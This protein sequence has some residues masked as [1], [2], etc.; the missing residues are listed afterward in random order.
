MHNRYIPAFVDWND[1]RY[2]LAISRSRTLLGAA[3]ALGTAHTTV[4]RRLKALEERLGV[5]LFDRTPDGLLPTAAGD[6]LAAVAE[7]VEREVLS[8]EG[9]VLGRDAQLRGS[10]R[11]STVDVV[12]CR[13]EDAFASFIDRYPNI[14]LSITA[15]R[16]LVSLTRREADVALRLSNDPPETLV[17]RKVGRVQFGVY[18]A[19]SLV[20]RVGDNAP[21]SD[22]PWIGWDG[23]P[24]VRWFEGWLSENASGARI[25]VRLDHRGLVMAHAVRSGIG[26]QILPCFLAAG[27]PTLAR[28]APLDDAFQLDLWLL[29]LPDLRTNSRVRVFFDHMAEALAARQDALAGA[30]PSPARREQGSPAVDR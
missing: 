1:L 7:Q 15:T 12:F 10:L 17:G 28:I 4:G 6:D 18:A 3:T 22:Y 2:V 21:L 5:L 16:E 26:A 14:E 19:P 20:E 23:G 8:A 29:T 13:F 27:D 30:E 11:V 25:A 24:N 9:R